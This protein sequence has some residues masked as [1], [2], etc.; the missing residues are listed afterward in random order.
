MDKIDEMPLTKPKQLWGPL[1]I[2]V[3]IALLIVFIT[4]GAFLVGWG[5]QHHEQHESIRALIENA[6][7]TN[8]TPAVFQ[9]L[10]LIPRAK[11]SAE[12]QEEG[13]EILI[14]RGEAVTVSLDVCD[15]VVCGEMQ[16]ATGHDVYGCIHAWGRPDDNSWCPNSEKVYWS[17]RTEGNNN[18]PSLAFRSQLSFSKGHHNGDSSRHNP[19]IIAF[20]MHSL[21]LLRK[22]EK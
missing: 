1:G 21:I 3:I 18:P 19:I 15:I 13:L 5:V 22:R 7:I 12:Q 8:K 20:K 16:D 14:P 11:R 2:R 10:S 9:R 4:M 17:A 6:H